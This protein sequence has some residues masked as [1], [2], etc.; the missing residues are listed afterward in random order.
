MSSADAGDAPPDLT[1]DANADVQADAVEAHSAADASD[2][3]TF[4]DSGL[5]CGQRSFDFEWKAALPMGAW[6]A[7]HGSPQVDSPVVDTTANELLLPFGSAVENPAVSASNYFLEFDLSIDGD[8]T[9]VMVPG[10]S[11]SNEPLPSIARSGPDLVLTTFTAGETT[12]KPGGGFQGQH[13]P[14]QKVHVILFADAYPEMLGMEVIAAGQT[15][16]S[17]FT[18]LSRPPEDLKLI[19]VNLPAEAGSTAHIHVGPMSG[20]EV[21]FRNPCTTQ[22]PGFCD[23]GAAP[24]F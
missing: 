22:S 17:G 23:G 15:F 2:A 18:V 5:A 8:L 7:L 6:L 4:G 12:T 14:A 11:F 9:F 21:A 16:W 13:I 19:S 10:F 24:P 3:F 1:P 20:C